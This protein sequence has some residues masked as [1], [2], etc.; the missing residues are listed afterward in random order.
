MTS[1]FDKRLRSVWTWQRT[2]ARALDLFEREVGEQ[3]ERHLDARW[4][5]TEQELLGQIGRCRSELEDFALLSHWA[6]FE[7]FVYDWLIRRTYWAGVSSEK[8]DCVRKGLSR[9]IQYWSFEEKLTALKPILGKELA[10]EL[11]ALRRWRNWVAHGKQEPRP[12]SFNFDQA[13]SLLTA[14]LTRLESVP[15]NAAKVLVERKGS[16]SLNIRRP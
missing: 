2:A 15:V 8:D 14:A 7:E 3:P 13:Q 6:I 1:N 16:G 11:N 10:L 5:T 4:A 9:R 12:V